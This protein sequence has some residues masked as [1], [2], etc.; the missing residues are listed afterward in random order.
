M[1]KRSDAPSR[2]QLSETLERHE[3][4]MSR[5]AEELETIASDVET[6]KDTLDS[7]DFSGTAEG[8]DEVE[9]TITDAQDVTVDIF[10]EQ[11]EG[12][13]QIQEEVED[14]QNELQDRHDSSESDLGKV[15]D[16]S[17]RVETQ[18]TINKLAESKEGLLKDIEFLR[19]QVDEA[20]EAKDESER[21]Q[22]TLKDKVSSKRR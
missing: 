18:E 6:I 5:K 22:N 16:A 21:V 3:G 19:S 4:D 17:G 14:Y 15:S 10:E 8:A 12:L 9:A 13:E 11:D 1:S 20:K 2:G 7:L